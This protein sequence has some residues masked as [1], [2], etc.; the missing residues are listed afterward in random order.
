MRWDYWFQKCWSCVE[1][2]AKEAPSSLPRFSTVGKG[3]SSLQA[4]EMEAAQ[5]PTVDLMSGWCR[6]TTVKITFLT[7]MGR[8]HRAQV[9]C[10]FICAYLSGVS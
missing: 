9:L 3:L 8:L 1:D 4:A 5:C 6:K 2:G 7:F 10:N